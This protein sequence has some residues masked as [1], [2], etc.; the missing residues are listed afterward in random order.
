[1]DKPGCIKL[2]LAKLERS[3]DHGVEHGVGESD[4]GEAV[5]EHGVDDLFQKCH[6]E[7]KDVVRGPA[8]DEGQHDHEGHTQ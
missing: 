5:Q 2:H 3:I 4:E 7:V 8:D 1:M 6:V